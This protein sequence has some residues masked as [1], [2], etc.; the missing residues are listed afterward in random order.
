MFR[1]ENGVSP[2]ARVTVSVRCAANSTWMR[3]APLTIHKRETG[4]QVRCG[5]LTHE[6]EQNQMYPVNLTD[7]RLSERSK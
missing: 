4:K 6:K 3:T 7:T 5:P 1:S 2:A